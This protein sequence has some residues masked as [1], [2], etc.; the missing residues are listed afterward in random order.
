MAELA[1]ARIAFVNNYRGPGL[2]GGETQ[3]LYVVRAC[4]A[5]GMEVHLVCEPG[6]ALGDE[7]AEAGA[8]VARYPLSA[9]GAAPQTVDRLRGFLMESKADI[10][11]SG[12]F[13]TGVLTRTA[14]GP[15]PVRVVTQVAVDPA[16]SALDGGSK[17][18]VWLRARVDALSLA[19]TDAVV[20]VSQAVADALL[21]RAWPP[22]AIRVIAN[23]VDAELLAEQAAEPVPAALASLPE[24][25]PLA[26][27]VA[28]LEPVKNVGG[29]VAAAAILA[30]TRPD[31]RYAVVGDGAQRRDLEALA[32][33]LGVSDKLLWLG[34]VVP[35][36]AAL[37]RFDVCVM[38]SLSEGMPMVALEAGAL[39]IPV[40]GSRVGGIPEV[41]VDGTTGVLV[42]ARDDHGF[43]TAMGALLEDAPTR[44]AMGEAA[45]ARVRSAFSVERMTEGYLGLYEELLS[46]GPRE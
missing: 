17:V 41:V 37:A 7:A 9:A 25:T 22:E 20:A 39:G 40:I 13:W 33:A 45:S 8:A 29:F 44:G 12:G 24:A 4:A 34:T 18:G 5:A 15:L 27:C 6:A 31:V 21:A 19:R 1:G 35:S 23:G 30:T 32:G 2:G 3:L 38:P 36:A 10:V 42:A 26:G 14:A 11:Q 43:A 16:A 46:R 28:R